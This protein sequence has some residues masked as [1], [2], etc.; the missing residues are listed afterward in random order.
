MAGQGPP[1]L[2]SIAALGAHY[3]Y[4]SLSPVAVTRQTLDRIA[5]RDGRDRGPL[6]GVKDL[7]DVA[8]VPATAYVRAQQFRREMVARFR[9]LFADVGALLPPA[10]PWV[11][12]AEDPTLNDEA[13][14]GEM[15]CSAVYNL[16]GLPA[17]SVRACRSDCRSSDPGARTS[18]CCRS[19]QQ[20]KRRRRWPIRRSDTGLPIEI[21][22]P[23]PSY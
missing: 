5:T 7:I 19:A 22:G 8:G 6:P 10:V 1:H 17:A 12:S 2:L 14:A 20:W 4:G 15:F 16:V 3:R 18:A 11:A 23:S 13:G 9:T 21:V